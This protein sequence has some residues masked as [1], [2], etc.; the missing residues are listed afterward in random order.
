MLLQPPASVM[1]PSLALR[2]QSS[3]ED[4]SKVEI[5][6]HLS[7]CPLRRKLNLEPRSRVQR[8]L[9]RG[10]VVCVIGRRARVLPKQT[11]ARDNTEKSSVDLTRIYL[12]HQETRAFNLLV[13][14]LSHYQSVPS[15]STHD[16]LLH[17]H[18]S[19]MCPFISCAYDRPG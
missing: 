14:G 12:R 1:M 5:N 18:T 9:S 2:A 4:Q 7:T 8:L 17:L 16:A 13:P 6:K 11:E 15:P 10:L 19:I 3:E